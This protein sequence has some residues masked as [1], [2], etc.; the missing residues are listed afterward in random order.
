MKKTCQRYDLSACA[1]SLTGW[2]PGYW[3]PG[4]PAEPAL[5]MVLL[6]DVAALPA[7]VAGSV[8][9]ALRDAG[10]LP[11]WNVQLN[12]RQA[13]GVEHREKPAARALRK[14]FRSHA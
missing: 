14:V 9:Q 13:E 7:R 8:H 3:K 2:H 5:G 12:A 10:L 1:W 4:T 6:P 11:D